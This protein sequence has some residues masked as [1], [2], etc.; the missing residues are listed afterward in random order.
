M[1]FMDLRQWMGLLAKEEELRRVT[2]EVDWDRELG[3]IARRV[4]EKKGPAL[5]FENIK[6]DRRGRCTKLLTGGLGDGRRLALALGFPKDTPN[7]HL[8]Q[9]VMR[10]N[11]ETVAPVIVRTGPVKEN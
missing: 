9:H 8:V 5:L 6:G 4:L 3:P 10:K 2:A 1:G 11:R 7:R